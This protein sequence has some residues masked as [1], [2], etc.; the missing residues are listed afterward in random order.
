MLQQEVVKV[1]TE[2][3]MEAHFSNVDASNIISINDTEEQNCTRIV[4]F[5][6]KLAAD[7]V[8]K[9]PTPHEFQ[10]YIL[11]QRKEWKTEDGDFEDYLL[12][13]AA[14]ACTATNKT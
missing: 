3:E 11:E 10:K 7:L 9:S 4:I 6:L 1:R 5:P 14:V 8:N 2:E 12:F 13:W